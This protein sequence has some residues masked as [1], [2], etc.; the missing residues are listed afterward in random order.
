MNPPDRAIVLCVD[1]KSHVQALNRTQ[2]ILP[3]SPR[4][5][6]RQT[7]ITNGTE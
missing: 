3:L 6:A 2:Q 5:P 1:E 7:M 4:V